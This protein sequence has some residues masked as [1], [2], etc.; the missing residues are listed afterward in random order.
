M[1]SKLNSQT[2]KKSEKLLIIA[3]EAFCSGTQREKRHLLGWT[4]PK[5]ERAQ[6]ESH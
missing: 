4:L 6:K 5:S 1:R 3:P 2:L